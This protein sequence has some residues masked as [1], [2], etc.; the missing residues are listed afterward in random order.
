MT[1]NR[2]GMQFGLIDAL[3]APSYSTL[4][5]RLQINLNNPLGKQF[6]VPI[7]SAGTNVNISLAAD[8]TITEQLLLVTHG[9]GYI[10]QTYVVFS[11][12]AQGSTQTPGEVGYTEEQVYFMQGDTGSDFISYVVGK[13][14]FTILHYVVSTGTG[15]GTYTSTAANY[16]LQVKYLICNNTQ[17][18]TTK[19]F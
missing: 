8:E 18:R 5:N 2:Y 9:L 10:P 14:T 11:L 17:I 12:L 15:S 7:I 16:N 4:N 6:D 19:L 13:D 3:H 1:A